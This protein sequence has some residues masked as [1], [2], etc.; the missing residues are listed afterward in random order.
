MLHVVEPSEVLSLQRS[1]VLQSSAF[2]GHP[3]LSRQRSS[4]PQPS[5]VIQSSAFRGPLVLSLQFDGLSSSSYG[6]P[7]TLHVSL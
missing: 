1:E 7:K 5:E 2:R 4:S 6:G 3:V